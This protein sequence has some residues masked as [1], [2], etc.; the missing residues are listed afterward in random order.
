[1][2]TQFQKINQHN[3]LLCTR[4]R[5]VYR[6][7]RRAHPSLRGVTRR[8]YLSARPTAWRLQPLVR[9]RQ[10]LGERDRE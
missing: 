3:I 6:S 1:M 4:K 9:N 7:D 8:A 10:H 5:D 2:S